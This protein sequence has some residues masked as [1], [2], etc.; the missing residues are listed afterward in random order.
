MKTSQTEKLDR[1]LTAVETELR[2]QLLD[3]L[4][5]TAESGSNMFTN[6]EF[7][8]FNLPAHHLRADAESLLK[9][10]RECVRLR[11][12]LGLEVESSVGTLYLAA[13][14]EHASKNQQRRGP[15]KLAAALLKAPRP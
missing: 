9:S 2:Q 12:V 13:C 7:N 8:P 1:E 6:S 14:E 10:A 15:R 11:E 5:E 4:P 3:L